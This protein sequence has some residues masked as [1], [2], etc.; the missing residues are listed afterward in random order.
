MKR[1]FDIILSLLLLLISLPV[2]AVTLVIVSVILF[3]LP[4]IRQ[5]RRISLNKQPV[6]IFKIRT[7][8]RCKGFSESEKNSKSVFENNE[9]AK[10]VPWFCR[11]LRRSGLDEMLQVINV[12]KGEMS[13]V[14]PRPLTER[15]LR[16]LQRESPQLYKE[17]SR[18]K[19]LPGITGYWQ[20]YGQRS[21]GEVNLVNCDLF[22]ERNKSLILDIRIIVRTVLVLLTA[23]HSDAIVAGKNKLK[24]VNENKTRLNSFAEADI[25]KSFL[26]VTCRGDW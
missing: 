2:L 21:L 11:W 23:S 4:V 5:R 20:V 17:R 12:L 22:Y 6:N 15:D 24:S 9:Y 1:F 7:I 25:K 18:I 19:S 8:R 16:I 14:G 3:D 13:L 26:F 10:Y